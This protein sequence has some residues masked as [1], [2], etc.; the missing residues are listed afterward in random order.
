MHIQAGIRPAGFYAGA[1]ARLSA[2]AVDHRVLHLER[3]EVQAL[4]RA[5]LGGDFHLEGLARG[6]PDLP[7]HR[8]RRFVQ[9]FLAAVGR[10][11]E[12]Y[13]HALR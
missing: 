4:E 1:L 11:R 5:V 13:Q 7:G 12:L 9:V 6:E 2:K 10:V 3:S 8:R